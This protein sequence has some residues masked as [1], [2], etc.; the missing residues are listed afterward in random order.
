M[1]KILTLMVAAAALAGCAAPPAQ[2]GC[3]AEKFDS[4]LPRYMVDR[5]FATGRTVFPLESLGTSEEKKTQVT[6]E[7]F[8]AATL[9]ADVIKTEHLSTRQLATPGGMELNVFRPDSDSLVYF[10]R[11]RQQDGCWYLWQFEDSSL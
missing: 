2:H 10:Y 11:F 5:Q 4:F 6:R 1:K 8:A 3:V 7:Q 9:L